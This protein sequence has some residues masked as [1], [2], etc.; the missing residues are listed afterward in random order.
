[1]C[2][3][4]QALSEVTDTDALFA[5]LTSLKLLILHGE[6]LNYTINQYTDYITYTLRKSFLPRS[7][8]NFPL[9]LCQRTYK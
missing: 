2:A 5:L 6:S 1:V 7:V 9:N 8:N 4:E 3:R